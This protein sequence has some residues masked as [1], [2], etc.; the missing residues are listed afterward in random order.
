MNRTVLYD[1]HVALGAQMVP[2]GGW[3]MPVMY[4]DGILAEHLTT[5]K[6]AGLFDVSHM[7]RFVFRGS[8]ALDF[9]QYALTNNAEALDTLEKGAQYTLIPTKDGTAVDDAY[10]YRFVDDEYLLVVNAGNRDK[11]WQHFQ[12]LLKKF[13]HVELVDRSDDLAMVS[14][15]G[16]A[17]RSIVSDIIQAGRVPEPARNALNPVTIA[18]ATVLLARTGYTGEP[19][20]FELFIPKDSA[21]EIWNLLIKKGAA[22]A[23]L[24]A[25]DTLRLEAALPLYGHELGTDP[26]GHEIPIFA[27]PLAK[28][29]VSFSPLKGDFV[30]RHALTRQYTAFRKHLF[31][32]FSSMADLPRMIRPLALA[33]RGIA[34]QGAKIY[35]ED[36]HV[37]YVTSGT[38]VP[39]WE[40]E[41][42]GVHAGVS[43]H[44]R[45]RSICLAYLDSD[46]LDEE[47]LSVDI[48]GKRV[49]AMA[50]PCHMRSESPPYTRPILFD[51]G[52]ARKSVESDTTRTDALRLLKLATA[53]HRWRQEACINL[54][55]S[56]MTASPLV[57]MLSISDPS[58]RYAEHR[59]LK[60]YYDAEVFYYQGCDFIDE[61]ETLLIR[62]M[63]RYFGCAEVETRVISGQMANTAVYSAML[64]YLN[65]ADRKREPRRMRMVM[66]NHI[67]KGGHLSA[68]PIG[69]LRD[70][71]ARDPATER[72]A[73]VNF[74]VQAD[75]PFRIDVPATLSLIDR[76]RPELI[77]FGKSMVISKEPVRQVRDFLDAQGMDSV[78]MYDMAHVLGLV[79]PHFQD[80]FNEGA[81]LVT[82]ST[83]KTFFGTQRGVVASRYADVDERFALWEAI[84]RRTF[85]GSVSNHHLG[86]MVGLLMAA[87]EMNHFRDAYQSAVIANAKAFAKALTDC[88]LHV[89]GDPAVGYTETHQVLVDVGYANG[90]EIARRLEANNIICNYQAG[91]GDESF[92]ASGF[93]RMGVSEMTRFGMASQGFED[94]AQLMS[95]V[96]VDDKNVKKEV[97]RLRQKYLEMRYCFNAD[98]FEEQLKILI[99]NLI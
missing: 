19:L 37:G 98:G 4:G 64:D 1:C 6:Q 23:G 40:F 30:G 52:R 47:P 54:I 53:N 14:I 17:S 42:Q 83:H 48:R 93:L 85:P 96:V 78:V 46:I 87:Y 27:C 45:R 81:D 5:R 38:M 51:H 79:G 20:G 99:E 29:G 88:G 33:G 32:D 21:V 56:E 10:L 86:T 89:A 41:G 11:D 12:Q 22:P 58:F 92:S 82:G 66:N 36:R 9:L 35:K 26:D 62:E 50:V 34:R 49:A 8:G 63:T 57:R 72:P 68:Q 70:F 95:A 80:P 55:P 31:R 25:R 61:I 67:G 3:E 73:V 7:G 59:K 2:F 15:Q 18:G 39:Y 43:D 74:P 71:V 65:R 94:L 44:T 69:A 84:E 28:F 76:H 97:S 90:P 13:D 60:A 75:N 24:G 16:P 77:I 91:P